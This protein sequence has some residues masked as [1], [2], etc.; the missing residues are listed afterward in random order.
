[1]INSV[2]FNTLDLV[3]ECMNEKG[4]VELSVPTQSVCKV[5]KMIINEREEG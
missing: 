4:E 2:K 1:M 3:F 5:L